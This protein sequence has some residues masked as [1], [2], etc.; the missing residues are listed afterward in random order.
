M[1]DLDSGVTEQ[2]PQNNDDFKGIVVETNGEKVDTQ[3]ETVEPVKT[4]PTESE[5]GEE[6]PKRPGRWERQF[7]KQQKEIEELKALVAQGKAPVTTEEPKGP[8][9]ESDFENVLDFFD[10]KQDWKV[11]QALEKQKEQTQKVTAESAKQEEFKQKV[12]AFSERE[13]K[14][15]AENPEYLEDMA[16]LL[17]VGA[18]NQPMM[19]AIVESDIGEQVSLFLSKNPKEAA[20]I[21]KLPERQMYRVLGLLEAHI[22]KTDTPPAQRQTAATAPIAPVRASPASNASIDPS[23]DQRSFEKWFYKGK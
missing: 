10:A 16:E 15:I 22:S 5:G 2:A 20:L 18:I 6:K 13:A 12:S 14:V 7:L 21:S 17:E 9:K 11:E 8:P 3:S 23:K 1:S 19:E 4:E